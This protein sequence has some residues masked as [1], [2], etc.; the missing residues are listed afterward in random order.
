[1]NTGGLRRRVHHEDV[2]GRRN[3]RLEFGAGADGLDEPL[4]GQD[5]YETARASYVDDDSDHDWREKKSREEQAW[6]Q[7]LSRLIAL[8][9][10]WFTNAVVGGGAWVGS[11]LFQLLLLRRQANDSQTVEEIYLSP[12]QAERLEDLQQR[13]SVP[14]DGSRAEHQDA[15]RALWHSAFPGRTLP[16]LV[17]EQWKEMGW[18]GTDPSTD[19]RGGGFI[20]LQNLLFFS[21]KFPDSFQR[22]LHKQEGKRATWEYP[23]A[24]AGLNISFMLI[25]MLD[26]KSAKP[27]SM[28]GVTFLKILA[29]D[30]MA[31]DML[32][33][34]AFEM[35]DAHWLAMRA[36]YMEFNAVLKATRMQLEREMMLED[37]CCVQD[38]PAFNLLSPS[39]T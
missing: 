15:L 1:M 33:C 9:A 21:R 20:S 12:I 32:Y 28:S 23:F 10:Q 2:G 24:V 38:L 8:W 4:L 22:L 37:V 36:S 13:L 3:E 17:S 26:L 6:T 30:E 5:R 18:Q 7:N 14:F 35:L 25:Q 11:T 27:T 34:V 39:K 16:G 19:F 31:F 29:E